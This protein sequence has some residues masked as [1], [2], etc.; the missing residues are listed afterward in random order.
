[1]SEC[2]PDE[3][4]IRDQAREW[5][6]KGE[7]KYVIGYERGTDGLGRPVFVRTPED[8]ERLVWNPGCLQNLTLYLADEFQRK[9]KRG[10]EPDLRPVGVVVKPCDSKTIVELMKE[11][12]VPRERVKII[13]VRSRGSVDAG[14]LEK[15]LEQVPMEKR[16]SIE[17]TEDVGDGRD[18]VVVRYDGGEVRVPRDDVQAAKCDVCVIHNPVVHDIVVGEDEPDPR[19]DDFPELKE[20]LGMDAEARWEYWQGQL[21][22]C[23]RC[24]ACRDVCPLCYC[25]E[26]VFERQKPYR[27]NENS[28]ELPENIFYHAVRALHL[29]GRCID[30]GECQRVCPMDIPVRLLNRFLIKRAK[31]RFKVVPGINA[32]DKPMF[33]AYDTGD[34]E[35]GIW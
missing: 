13:G 24:Y 9:P 1:M 22:R 28:V 11:N 33:G 27:W 3:R 12:I 6:E 2:T 17:I 30:C 32:D 26:C 5:L 35:E 14:K 7:V 31:E 16:H 21:S 10:E 4:K 18:E 15:L 23:V 34:P 29:A 8:A 25:A 19:P 20:L